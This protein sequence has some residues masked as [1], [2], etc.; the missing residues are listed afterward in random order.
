VKNPM[1][2]EALPVLGKLYDWEVGNLFGVSNQV[3]RDWRLAR[4]VESVCKTCRIAELKQV[5]DPGFENRCPQHAKPS[6]A[7][8]SPEPL[9]LEE[10]EAEIVELEERRDAALVRVKALSANLLRGEPLPGWLDRQIRP[11]RDVGDEALRVLVTVDKN[12][13]AA[14][15]LLVRQQ[16]ENGGEK[17]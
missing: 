13:D 2:P 1:P 17:E 12:K 16:D 7:F 9:D 15:E 14:L 11:F 5:D 10:A 4:G 3:A 6:P 8:V